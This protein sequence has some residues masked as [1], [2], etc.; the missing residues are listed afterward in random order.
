M[1]WRGRAGQV[2]FDPSTFRQ[3]SFGC[4]VFLTLTN[5]SLPRTFQHTYNIQ[6]IIT[7]CVYTILHMLYVVCRPVHV[8]DTHVVYIV[9]VVVYHF[10]FPH[11]F[12]QFFLFHTI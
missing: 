9:V 4:H 5:E 3:S 1:R 10:S 11:C 6:S 2:W 7:T 8:T 12:I